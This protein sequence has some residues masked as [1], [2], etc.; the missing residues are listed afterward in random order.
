[1]A[2][3][4][5]LPYLEPIFVPAH[6]YPR[7]A[8]YQTVYCEARRGYDVGHEPVVLRGALH[9]R[10]WKRGGYRHY[11]SE[12]LNRYIRLRRITETDPKRWNDW[13][14]GDLG[15]LLRTRSWWHRQQASLYDIQ[16]MV[17]SHG[18][19]IEGRQ[20]WFSTTEAAQNVAR[21]GAMYRRLCG[22]DTSNPKRRGVT[23]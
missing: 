11:A 15:E 8:T 2:T 9:C 13:V 10:V 5:E 3:A 18:A 20:V 7:R 23:A 1:M 21:I 6:W 22:A 12:L 16:H 4:A 14:F 17:S 19:V